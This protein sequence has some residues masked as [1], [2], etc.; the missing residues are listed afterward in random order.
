M[1]SFPHLVTRRLEEN[2]LTQEPTIFAGSAIMKIAETQAS[3]ELIRALKSSAP[4]TGIWDLSV[5]ALQVGEK[6]CDKASRQAT[7]SRRTAPY[8]D[9]QCRLLL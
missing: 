9:L 6:P 8:A 5:L 3:A 2:S 4:Q 1:N 7:S